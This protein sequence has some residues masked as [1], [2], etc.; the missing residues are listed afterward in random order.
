MELYQRITLSPKE[1][2]EYRFKAITER[3]EHTVVDAD[4]RQQIADIY[5]YLLKLEFT[6]PADYNES[7]ATQCAEQEKRLM[8]RNNLREALRK[9]EKEIAAYWKRM[10]KREA[11]AE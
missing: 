2:I 1:A 8:R 3:L 9:T 4:E 5:Y 11:L 10:G 7:D 6:C